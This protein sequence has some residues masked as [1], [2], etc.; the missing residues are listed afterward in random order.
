MTARSRFIAALSA[1]I[2]WCVTAAMLGL[3][4][5]CRGPGG[6]LTF[7]I[8]ERIQ[9]LT[10]SIAAT[11]TVGIWLDRFVVPPRQAY[12]LGIEAGRR[13]GRHCECQA[14]GRCDDKTVRN[15]TML[16]PREESDG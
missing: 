3:G 13:Q 16:M 11:L 6:V 9:F 2:L 7:F 12:R 15:I 8:S 4:L 14:A 10:G 5:S 1:V